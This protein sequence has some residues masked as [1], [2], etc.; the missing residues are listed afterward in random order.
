MAA[1][2]TSRST[3]LAF[4]QARMRPL[5]EVETVQTAWRAKF[6]DRPTIFE[7]W[8]GSRRVASGLPKLRQP[9]LPNFKESADIPLLRRAY[10]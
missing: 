2:G 5:I 7:M 8:L 10:G 3:P 1:K 9:K 4:S 6:D